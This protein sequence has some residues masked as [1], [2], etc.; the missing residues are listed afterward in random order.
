M[1]PPIVRGTAA[2]RY[3]GD[4][5]D[6]FLAGQ[7]LVLQVAHPVV[8][9]GVRD[10]S[11]Y[12]SDPW[13]RLLRTVASLSIYVYGGTAGAQVE[14][15]RLRS[16]HRSFTGV[17]E[18]R[19]YSALDPAAYAWVHA[20]LVKAPVDA[21]RFFGVPLSDVDLEEYYAQMRGI[22]R[23]LGVR[24]RDLPPDWAGF[25]RYYDAMVS[26]FGPNPTIET[27]L[28]TFRTVAKPV[29][30][31]PDSWWRAVQRGQMFL[32]RATLPPA[33]RA[34]LGLQWTVSD[35]RRFARFAACVRVV[36][37]L[38]P[39]WVRTAPMRW[40]G[41]LNV[42]FRAHPKVYER[43]IGGTGPGSTQGS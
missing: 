32:I 4:V 16:L 37:A 9:A 41:K 42:W 35:Q 3:Y 5:R 36:G 19:R 34:A 1:A 12:T 21:Q 38:I 39:A 25:E 23:L 6:A 40:V 22:G 10:H 33:L 20:T 18:G 29:E 43:L 28:E 26:G 27:L 7:V 11:D 17:A 2:W 31:V 24:E 8:A 13:T 15:A 30:W 14:A